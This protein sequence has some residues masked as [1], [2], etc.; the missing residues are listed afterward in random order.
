MHF[1]NFT[2]VEDADI[3]A[4]IPMSDENTNSRPF[5]SEEI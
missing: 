5:R 3:L 4:G 1:E 2:Y